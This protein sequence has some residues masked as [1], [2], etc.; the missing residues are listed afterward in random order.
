RTAGV[1]V[2]SRVLSSLRKL[3]RWLVDDHRG[4]ADRLL[5]ESISVER[6]REELG[7][8]NGI[9]RATADVLLLFGLRRPVYPVDRASYR[10]MVRHGWIDPTADYEEA[11]AVVERQRTDTPTTFAHLSSG[12][13]RIGRDFCRVSSPRCD[14]CPLRPWLPEG[15]P[16]NPAF[17]A[18]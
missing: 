14:E 4:S 11:Q 12:M 18:D 1:T 9:G 5:E 8:V 6:L 17:S 2:P 3:A 15:G 13:E 7:S 10:I 16:V